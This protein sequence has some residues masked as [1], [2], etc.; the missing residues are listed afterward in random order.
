MPVGDGGYI[1][2]TKAAYVVRS[3]GTVAIVIYLSYPGG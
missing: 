2:A 1:Q 3:L